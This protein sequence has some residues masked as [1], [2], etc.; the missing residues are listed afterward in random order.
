M[1][2]TQFGFKKVKSFLLS[3]VLLQ[4]HIFY[5]S[6]VKADEF[7]TLN[8]SVKSGYRYDSNLFRL[9]S[10][11]Q[12][13]VAGAEK[14]DQYFV[15]SIGIKI[16]KKYSLQQFKL[17]FDHVDTRY[18]NADF[19]NFKA[20]NY[21]AEWLWAIT[22]NLTGVLSAD[23]FMALVPFEDYSNNSVASTTPVQNIRTSERQVFSFDFS[24]HDKWHLIGAYNN[25]SVTNSKT[26]LPE[27]SFNLDLIEAGVKYEFPSATYISF[28]SRKS[29][30]QNDDANLNGLIGKT[31]DEYQQLMTMFWFLSGKS[32]LYSTLGYVEKKDNEFSV[33]DFSGYIGSI[34]YSWDMTGKTNLTSGLS[35]KIS[36][37][38]TSTDSYRVTDSI[39][40]NPAWSLTSKMTV[41]ANII[42]AQDNFKGDGFL[43]DTM[44]RQDDTFSYGLGLEW[45]PRRTIKLGINIQH[46]TRDSNNDAAKYS[47]NFAAVNGQLLF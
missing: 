3:L 30:G 29:R 23:R 13:T 19:L 25:L 5:T 9:P 47:A 40:I 35:R 28:V 6:T 22:P 41:E 34:E 24:P 36:S 38:T 18:S 26:F 16:N 4:I 17:D 11:S 10:G 2:I 39:Y 8:L 7:D 31:F 12:P 14:S 37:F 27:S 1:W 43:A 32:K 45:S 15:N 44:Q 33:R 20:N 46:Q 21:K 42:W